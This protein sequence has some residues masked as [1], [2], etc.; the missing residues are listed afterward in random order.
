MYHG[1]R[2][3][4][5]P[6]HLTN[7]L[8]LNVLRDE[9]LNQMTYL[10]RYYDVIHLSEALECMK[11]GNPLPRKPLVITFDDGYMNNYTFAWPVCR[12]LGIPF[13][14]YVAADFIENGNLLWTDR[15]EFAITR[16]ACTNLDI[17]IEG[18]SYHLPLSTRH[19]RD[20]ANMFLL[21]VFKSIDAE[22]I[23][24]YVQE[25][26]RTLEISTTGNTVERIIPCTWKILHEMASS[27]LVEIGSHTR[28]HLILTKLSEHMIRQEL[29]ESKAIIEKRTGNPCSHFSYPNGKKDD[30][31]A[32]TE[33]LVRDAGYESAVTC[34]EGFNKTTDNPFTLKRF[35]IYGHYKMPEFVGMICGLHR[36]FATASKG[37]K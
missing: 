32:L 13:T 33:K 23:L 37:G 16:T 15:L 5:K 30:F 29:G 22:K 10:K 19:Y 20:V 7:Y 12:E 18:G 4:D 27:G 28:R 25:L 11:N 26:E 36:I 21:K 8:H 35:G 17:T 1:V 31:N 3:D 14:I 2:T 9:F 6:T 24:G 34:I